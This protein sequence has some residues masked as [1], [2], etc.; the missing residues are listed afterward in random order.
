MRKALRFCAVIRIF[1]IAAALSTWSQGGANADDVRA[2]IVATDLRFPEGTI[3]IGNDLYFVDYARSSVLRL[4]GG[5]TETVWHQDGCGANGLVA[6]P[7]G[8]LV[9]CFDSGTIVQISAAGATLTTIRADD[10]GQ[11]LV[12][13]ND[14]TA[15]QRGGIYVSDSGSSS[16]PGKVFYLSRN[17]VLHEMASGF[18]SP[19]V[20][21]YR[22]KVPP[23]TLPSH[24]PA[25]CKP[26]PSRRTDPWGQSATSFAFA[27]SSPR[28]GTE[29]SRP[30]RCASIP[31]AT[32]SSRYITV[33][34]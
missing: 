22:P 23:S 14:L 21:A 15:D 2:A 13:P 5:K 27:T 9:A 26:S 11:T 29:L 16:R 8:L 17:Q 7:D 33:V 25:R 10:R 30:T 28:A 4:V 19:T 32:S 20:S 6:V 12:A 31:T 24:R 3:F 34:A 18:A 1:I